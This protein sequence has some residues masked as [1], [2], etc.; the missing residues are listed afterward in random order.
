[1]GNMRA[2][3]IAAALLLLFPLA[4]S[5]QGRPTQPRLYHCGHG[6]SAY[7]QD[8]PCTVRV[9]RR[10]AVA[11]VR[12]AP[13]SNFLVK[14]LSA[15][16]APESNAPRAAGNARVLEQYFKRL[17]TSDGLWSGR[18]EGEGKV[19]LELH[20]LRDGA[21]ESRRYMGNVELAN[22]SSG[23]KFRS[24]LPKGPGWEWRVIA[25]NS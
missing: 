4:L 21:V 12:A 10:T 8:R 19:N 1:M 22:S 20:I 16:S 11:V 9:P 15:Q 5:A 2:S 6:P 17:S 24:S 18:V 3:L 13:A 14:N 25:F 23:F 7:V